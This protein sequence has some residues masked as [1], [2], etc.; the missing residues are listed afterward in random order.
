MGSARSS[1][2]GAEELHLAQRKRAR[3]QSNDSDSL[4]GGN[5][6]AAEHQ[7]SIGRPRRKLA[8]RAADA[9]LAEME[10][11][12]TQ[13]QRARR[14]ATSSSGDSEAGA[15]ASV[16]SDAA[17]QNAE[18]LQELALQHLTF[19]ERNRVV[20]FPFP[21]HACVAPRHLLHVIINYGIACNVALQCLKFKQA[22]LELHSMCAPPLHQFHNAGP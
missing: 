21:T 5:A 4:D 19:R 22:V 17:V 15:A 10:R 3:P 20:C 7:G 16:D 8:V 18:Q 12:R 9:A 11:V 2:E 6:A 13:T 14:A 1:Q